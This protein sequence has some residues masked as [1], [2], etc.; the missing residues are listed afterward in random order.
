MARNPAAK[1]DAQ[2]RPVRGGPYNPDNQHGALMDMNE[3]GQISFADTFVGDLL[4]FD[5][6]MGLHGNPGMSASMQG[7]R[8]LQQSGAPMTQQNLQRIVDSGGGGGGGQPSTPGAQ[9]DSAPGVLPQLED[10]FPPGDPLPDPITEHPDANTGIMTPAALVGGGLGVVAIGEL[11]RRKLMGDK[12]AAAQ[13]REQ[14]IEVPDTLTANVGAEPI[15]TDGGHT[16]TPITG[17]RTPNNNPVVLINGAP[18]MIDDMGRVTQLNDDQ[19]LRYVGINA[20]ASA[21]TNNA[22]RSGAGVGAAGSVDQGVVEQLFRIAK[23]L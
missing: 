13:L 6:R 7:A 5:G 11:V 3:D 23:G 19:F 17:A 1:Q 22:P 20:P 16:I 9:P 21:G 4:G 12:G 2:G 14:G 18:A 10:Q 15:V 8:R